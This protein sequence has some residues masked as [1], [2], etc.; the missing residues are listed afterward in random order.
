[1][2]NGGDKSGEIG[3]IGIRRQ[4]AFRSRSLESLTQES[5]AFGLPLGYFPASTRVKWSP[6]K[7]TGDI[8]VAF[9]NRV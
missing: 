4:V 8:L 1:M 2:R 5:F 7:P 6:L 3:R 9:L